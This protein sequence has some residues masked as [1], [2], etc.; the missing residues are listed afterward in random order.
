MS[1]TLI[2]LNPEVGETRFP[3]KKDGSYKIGA[4]SSNDIV[5]PQRDISREHAVLTIKGENF[6][7]VDLKSKNGTFVNGNRTAA[8][9]FGPG[10]YVNLSSG[11]FV[12]VDQ[13]SETGGDEFRELDFSAFGLDADSGGGTTALC[14]C[15]DLD[16]FVDLFATTARAIGGGDDADLLIWGV[17]RLGLSSGMLLQR[18]SDGHVSVISSAGD[19]GDLL[20]R[21]L[22]LNTLA[23][24]ARPAQ[25]PCVQHVQELGSDVI[26]AA[27]RDRHFLVLQY[28]SSPPAVGDILILSAAVN[29]VLMGKKRKAEENSSGLDIG[30]LRSLPLAEA[31]HAFEDWMIHEVLRDC[32]G[33]QS[34]AARR[35]G[36]T[37]AGLYKRMKKS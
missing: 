4:S 5:F 7:I 2:Y 25:E 22:D 19:L 12:I 34:E 9:E 16:D 32:A 26:L 14:R 10:D 30:A 23:D 3:L 17:S 15:L 8:A 11:R 20:N 29:M 18:S 6:R 27:L 1:Y 21:D 13:A 36:M 31:R 24:R 37:R 33:N 35:L 28:E